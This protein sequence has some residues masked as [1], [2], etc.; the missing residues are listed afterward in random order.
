MVTIRLNLSMQDELD[1]LE[2]G[3]PH[4]TDLHPNFGVPYILRE[5]SCQ[6]LHDQAIAVGYQVLRERFFSIK[7]IISGGFQEEGIE[8]KLCNME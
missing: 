3:M 1:F 4:L 5:V 8:K 6:N 7:I 2:G